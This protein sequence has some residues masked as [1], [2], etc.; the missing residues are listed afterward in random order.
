MELWTAVL[1]NGGGSQV[2]VYIRE[3]KGMAAGEGG[4]HE[5]LG[6]G[7]NQ[8]MHANRSAG[9]CRH[10]LIFRV[11]AASGS[12]FLRNSTKGWLLLD[13]N[14]W[15][16]GQVWLLP[17]HFRSRLWN[18]GLDYIRK[19]ISVVIGSSCMNTSRSRWLMIYIL[20]I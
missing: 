1:G 19:W 9:N 18:E 17:F 3:M 20:L 13:P 10:A 15:L 7:S 5:V 16:L 4:V 8:P 6:I 11:F 2:G 12:L 14:D